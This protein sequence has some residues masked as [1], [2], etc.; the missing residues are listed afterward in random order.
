MIYTTIH[1]RER[2]AGTEAECMASSLSGSMKGK[3]IN[4]NWGV[5]ESNYHLTNL[6]NGYFTGKYGL[7]FPL[8]PK[9]VCK[10]EK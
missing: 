1:L 6:Y 7:E 4:R 9:Q 3:V 5:W 8:H 2:E 10:T